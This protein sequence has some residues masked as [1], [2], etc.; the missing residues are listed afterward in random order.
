MTT[1]DLTYPERA[2][3]KV[4]TAHGATLSLVRQELLRAPHWCGYVRFPAPLFADGDD[5]SPLGYVPVHGG[6]TYVHIDDDGS[7]VYGFDCAHAGDEHDLN[8]RDVA[9][10]T[11]HTEQFAA[12]LLAAADDTDEPL[13]AAVLDESAAPPS[14]PATTERTDP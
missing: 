10:L 3:E 8:L 11:A 1:I 5:N 2:A 9:W 6:V 14:L 4:W 13:I 7:A 12:A